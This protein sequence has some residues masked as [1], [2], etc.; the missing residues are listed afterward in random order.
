MLKPVCA[1]CCRFYRPFRNGRRFVEGMPKVYGARPG[2]A[3]ADEWQ[4]YKIW[5][6]DEWKCDGCNAR[7]IVGIPFAPLSEHYKDEFAEVLKTV[8]PF[9]QVNDC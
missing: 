6:G 2:I 1:T 4:P 3:H 5:I 7:I 9:L 8:N